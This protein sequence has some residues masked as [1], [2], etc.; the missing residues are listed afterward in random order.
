MAT[1]ENDLRTFLANL[2]TPEDLE[3]VKVLAEEQRTRLQEIA[4]LRKRFEDQ[5]A[6]YGLTAEAVINGTVKKPRRGRPRKVQ[7]AASE[8]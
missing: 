6:T 7:D 8:E 1:T 4:E 2:T 3:L 5:A